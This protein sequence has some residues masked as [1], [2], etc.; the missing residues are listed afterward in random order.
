[1]VDCSDAQIMPLSNVLEWMMELTATHTSA[2]SSMMAGV[3]PAPT[4]RAGLPEEYAALTMPGPPV[5]RMM[6]AS[7]IAMFVSSRDGISIQE[8]MSSGAPAATAASSTTFAAAMVD[9][10][11]R[12][13]GEMMMPLRVFRQISVLKIAVDVGF[14]VGITAATTPMGSATFIMPYAS[15]R[16]STPTV[17]VSL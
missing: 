14:V 10:F 11:A 16:S 4:P 13:C 12:G 17:C 5:A 2:E 9:F 8:M 6:S 1:M 7:F 15:L 3:L